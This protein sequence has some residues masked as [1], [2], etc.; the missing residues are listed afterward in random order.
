MNQRRPD[1]SNL[2]SSKINEASKFMSIEESYQVQSNDPSQLNS[3]AINSEIFISPQPLMSLDSKQIYRTKQMQ[4][5]GSTKSGRK[6]NRQKVS[7]QMKKL[8]L[9]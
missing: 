1:G 2:K 8:K 7:E 4:K 6:D 9:N 3:V 5:E